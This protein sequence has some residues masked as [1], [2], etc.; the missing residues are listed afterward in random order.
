MAIVTTMIVPLLLGL[1]FFLFGMNVMSGGLET[2]AGGGLERTMK[3]VTANDFLGFF[4]GAGIT[5]AIQSSSAMTV[6]LVGLVNSGLVEFGNTFG[7]IMG[8]N[9]GT[10]LTAWLL[11]LAG[12]EGKWYIE[13]LNPSVFAPILAFIGIAMQ[14]FTKS[15]KKKDLGNVFIGFAILICGMD[16]MSDSMLSVRTLPGFDTFLATLKSPI[17]ALLISTAFTGVIQSS[18]ATIGIV[19]ALA[20]SGGITWEMAIPLVLGANIG[21]CVTALIGSIGTN[22]NAKRVVVMHFFVNVFGSLLC[23][24]ILY[25]LKAFG[26]SILT[27]EIAMVGVAIVHT[28]FNFINTVILLPIKK[29]LIK[30]CEWVIPDREEKQHTVFLDERIFNNSPLAISECRR[31]TNEMA[32]LTRKSLRKAIDLIFNYQQYTVEQIR[33]EENLSDKYED[34][35]G[36]YLVRLSNNKLSENES[37]S[38]ARMLHSI[39]DFERIGDHALNI[40]TLAEEM[41]TKGISFSP[42]GNHEIGIIGDAVKEITSL[43]IDSFVNDNSESASHVEPLEQV[44]DKLQEQLKALHIQRLQNNECT[45]ELGFIFTDILNNFERV[46]DHCSNIAVYTMQ[47]PSDKLD[48]HKYLNAIKYSA[49]DEF[50]QDYNMYKSKYTLD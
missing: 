11:S 32:E 50:I 21:T 31:L 10:T 8:S 22:K 38:V 41:H 7:M 2:M 44:I 15:D 42:E 6:M 29:P 27:T 49:N 23:M 13:I 12:L 34:K 48:T 45:I 35:L 36:T 47:L 26:L 46:S 24:V 3:K 9:V 37:H 40:C 1:T 30:F 43:A 17:I 4:L 5:V 33:E 28:L 14:M 20:L 39:G 18:A 19:Q 16:L 25:I